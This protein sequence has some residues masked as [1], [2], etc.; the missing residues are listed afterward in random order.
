MRSSNFLYSTNTWLSY[1][2]GEEYYG[3]KHFVWCSPY[4]DSR[5]AIEHDFLLPPTSCPKE[6]YLSLSE[7]VVRRDHHS[8]KIET[9]KRGIIRGAETKRDRG[10]I[11]DEQFKEIN[12]IIQLAQI[13]D[14]KP[15]LYVIL[16]DAVVPLLR[17]V[18]VSERAHPVSPE[19]IVESLPRDVFDVLDF[20]RA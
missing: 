9:T 5:L 20:G 10:D 11:S 18:A 2:I 12:D 17:R 13:Q 4:F 14:F 1:V 15:L 19:F 7:E 6:I 16:Y 3:G 8:A